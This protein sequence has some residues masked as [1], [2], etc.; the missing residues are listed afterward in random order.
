MRLSALAAKFGLK[1]EIVGRGA[2]DMTDEL[3]AGKAV[4]A[5]GQNAP[6]QVAELGLVSPYFL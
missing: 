1:A 4:G 3:S 6:A 5:A 2:P